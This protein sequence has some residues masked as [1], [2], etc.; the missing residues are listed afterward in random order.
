MQHLTAAEFDTLRAGN[1][2]PRTTLR[3]LD[4]CLVCR[5]AFG[6]EVKLP[7]S[8]APRPWMLGAAAALAATA[9][10]ASPLR[11]AAGSFL[12]IFE[13]H[14]VAFVPVTLADM[15]QLGRMP[16][17]SDYGISREPVHSSEVTVSYAPQASSLARFAVRVPSVGIDVTKG[18]PQF[19]VASPAVAQFVFSSAR[20]RAAAAAQHRVLAP[21]PPGLDGSMLEIDLGSSVVATYQSTARPAHAFV[22]GPGNRP[23]RTGMFADP[24]ANPEV[25]VAQ[26][27]A[28][29]IFS[30]GAS[31]ATLE[32]YLLQQPGFPPHLAAALRA[33]GDP[34]TTLPIPIP[35]DKAYAVPLIVDGVRGIGIGDDTGLGAAVIWQKQGL[36]YGVFGP[37]TAHDVL[38]IADSLR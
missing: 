15:R 9:L 34:S 7:S 3:H 2:V 13:P 26:M 25:I 27:R 23:G 35:V 22:A 18:P 28:P 1:P 21:V 31:A 8:R 16:E 24:T 33:L 30:T 29:K 19:R 14:T 36:L 5:R 32:S 20:A 12:E 4:G 37:L 17:L 11:S 10:I 38:A 6:Q